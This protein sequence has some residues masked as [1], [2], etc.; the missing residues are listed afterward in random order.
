MS[1]FPGFGTEKNKTLFPELRRGDL[2]ESDV[3]RVQDTAFL[4]FKTGDSLVTPQKPAAPKQPPPAASRTRFP[5]GKRAAKHS[6][7]RG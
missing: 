4:R 1:I 5:S 6:V 7:R 2:N 3:K